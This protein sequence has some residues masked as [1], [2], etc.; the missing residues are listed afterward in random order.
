[1]APRGG[2]AR[3]SGTT[4][5][6]S[7]NVRHVWRPAREA[8]RLNSGS[9]MNVSPAEWFVDVSCPVCGDRDADVLRRSCF[10]AGIG[11]SELR[12]MFQASSDHALM[13]QVVKCRA[14][15]MVYLA[16]RLDAN[17]IQSGYEE[18]ED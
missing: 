17:L 3:R 7:T 10:P 1:M 8:A 2:S 14:C 11:V 4:R 6:P 12:A 15:R 5:S 13:D 16:P 9:L 18:A